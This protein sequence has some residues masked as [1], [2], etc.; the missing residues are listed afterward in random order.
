MKR[1]FIA[2]DIPDTIRPFLYRRGCSLP[3]A[4]AVPEE[5]IHL[6]LRFIGEV[7]GGL[8]LDIRQALQAVQSSCF[9]LAIQGAGHFPP[10]G[11]PRVV[12]AGVRPADPVTRLKRKIDGCLQECGI[13][14]DKR[15]FS[16]HIT[17]ARLNDTP[18]R[19]VSE[20]LADNALLS[21][22]AFRVDQFHLYSS[23]LHAKGAVHTLE[24]SYGLGEG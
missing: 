6:T 24:A 11:K 2:L 22:D 21:F 12:W 3:Y 4:K 5:Q 20:F 16:P 8:F 9:D 18:V 19:R 1:L 14:P 10:R 15:K 17:L 7:E 13:T 23:R